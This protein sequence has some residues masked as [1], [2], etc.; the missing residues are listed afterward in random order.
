MDAPAEDAPVKRT[1]RDAAPFYDVIQSF[2]P[3]ALTD[4]RSFSHVERLREDPTIPEIFGML[5]V[6]CD[7]MVR[8]S[9]QDV[10]SNPWSCSKRSTR[11]C[12]GGLGSCPA[13]IVQRQA[14]PVA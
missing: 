2:I 4:G 13:A 10:F 1:R 11:L 7:D 14:P 5:A 6:V 12:H 9:F 3:T 8:W